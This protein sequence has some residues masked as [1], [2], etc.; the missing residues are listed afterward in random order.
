M[1]LTAICGVGLQ[2]FDGAMFEA[3]GLQDHLYTVIECSA[4]GSFAHIISSINSYLFA[5]DDYE[6]VVTKMM[7]PNTH[8]VLL[9][10]S[11]HP[12]IQFNLNPVNDK[13]P[14]PMP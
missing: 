7:H 4:K 8:I 6:A 14:S 9:T 1:L 2:P 12:D 11:E 5:P 13:A 3:S 10:E